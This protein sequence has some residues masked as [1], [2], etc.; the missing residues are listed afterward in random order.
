MLSLLLNIDKRLQQYL[1][2][3]VLF[4]DTFRKNKS[5]STTIVINTY[6]HYFLSKLIVDTKR[7]NYTTG[8]A[9][10]GHWTTLARYT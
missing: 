3:I 2:L 4:C 9:Y 7:C 5:T 1:L 8:Y 10:S 6:A